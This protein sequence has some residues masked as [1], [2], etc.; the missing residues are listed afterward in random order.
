MLLSLLAN[1]G[2]AGE[3][4]DPWRGWVTFKEYARLVDEVPDPGISVQLA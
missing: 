3:A 4:L 2:L 1:K